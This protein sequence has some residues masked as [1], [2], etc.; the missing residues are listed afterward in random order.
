MQCPYCHIDEDRVIDSRATEGGSVVRRRRQCSACGKRFT[1][2]ERAETET[3]LQVIKRD[4][5]R[6]PYDREKVR[7]GVKMACYKRPVSAEQIDVLLNRVEE[8]IFRQYEREVPSRAIGQEV[9]AQL[10]HLD[11]V[12][13]I[14]FASVYHQF[15][16]LG[17]LVHEAQEVLGDP[18]PP[19]GQQ[20]L[21]DE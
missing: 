2:Y 8:A 11:K 10:R 6:V 16:D 15:R 5:K 21:F 18:D 14:R 13:Y 20:D 1:T 17:E 19:P 12:A 3:G 9:C 7:Q 4:R